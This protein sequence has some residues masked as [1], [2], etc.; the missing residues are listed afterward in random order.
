MIDS[1]PRHKFSQKAAIRV[2]T[3]KAAGHTDDGDALGGPVRT[4]PEPP[5]PSRRAS[6]RR[7]I[8]ASSSSLN[9]LFGIGKVLYVGSFKVTERPN[10][11]DRHKFLKWVG[12]Q[13]HLQRR[14]QAGKVERRQPEIGVEAILRDDFPR[15]Q[16]LFLDKQTHL[17]PDRLGYFSSLCASSH[18]WEAYRWLQK[19][20]MLGTSEERIRS[21]S[22]CESSIDHDGLPRNEGRG[23]RNHED[24]DLDDLLYRRQPSQRGPA[25]DPR[26]SLL[27][28][29]FDH[30]ALEIARCDRVHPDTPRSEL[31]GQAASH[32]VQPG[33]GRAI[34]G[35]SAVP[36]EA[37]DRRNVN[38]ATAAPLDH[39]ARA[40][41]GQVQR[42]LQV[43]VDAKVNVG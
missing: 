31:A 7:R 12:L 8:L 39:E 29:S 5:V 36:S 37:V 20:W 13:L 28:E 16:I 41:P 3:R 11:G 32:P 2:G 22:A 10:A 33:L 42:A 35:H 40:D 17:I 24:H 38:D 21:D 4:H 1:I 23:R 27:V 9:F 18:K 14:H 26:L 34:D 6:A 15:R 19:V 25:S 43:E 30:F